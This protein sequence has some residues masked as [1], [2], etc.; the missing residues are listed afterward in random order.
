MALPL[1]EPA[2]PERPAPSMLAFARSRCLL[3]EPS[4]SAITLNVIYL[5]GTARALSLGALSLAYYSPFHL[6]LVSNGCSADEERF[7]ARLCSA[8]P[9]LSFLRL[10]VDAIRR[11]ASSVSV[12]H[13]L[14]L[15]HLQALESS[16]YF[17]F[18][19]SDIFAV[20]KF[21]VDVDFRRPGV[22]SALPS[23][24]TWTRREEH[25]QAVK[26]E[27]GS[28]FLSIYRNDVLTKLRREIGL[29]FEIYRWKRLPERLRTRLERSGNARKKLDTGKLLN[30]LLALEGHSTVW[31]DDQNLRHLG[32]YS[33]PTPAIP[34]PRS[35]PSL[36]GYLVQKI[37]RHA[38]DYRRGG[39]LLERRRFYRTAC[40]QHFARSLAALDRGEP[41]P[42]LPRL[43]DAHVRQKLASTSE[44]LQVL[45]ELL[46]RD[47]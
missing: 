31:L 13:G 38:K 35:L 30:V 22:F 18:V 45:H 7:L 5:C 32:G 17:G 25:F 2:P 42:E 27:F 34:P 28:S 19:D 21:A 41:L 44:E 10:P 26:N 29:G 6:R 4:E 9:R 33:H 24:T 43:R 39:M 40:A 36:P 12:P 23:T 47:A 15:N 1:E 16:P 37:R 46:V 8:H 11:D 20:D 3:S 14:A